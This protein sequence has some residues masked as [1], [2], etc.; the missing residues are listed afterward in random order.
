MEPTNESAVRCPV[1][2]GPAKDVQ[3]SVHAGTEDG[4]VEPITI[5]ACENTACGAYHLAAKQNI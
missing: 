5:C 2:G 3:F 4:S 1:C